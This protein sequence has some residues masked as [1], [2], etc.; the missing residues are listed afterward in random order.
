MPYPTLRD[1]EAGI[2][3]GREDT[4][5]ALAKA[6][7]CTVSDLYIDPKK[8]EIEAS[9]KN[10]LKSLKFEHGSEAVSS[11]VEETVVRT[12][13]K[14]GIT[15]DASYMK[16]FRLFGGLSDEGKNLAIS[17]LESLLKTHSRSSR[18]SDVAT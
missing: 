14:M 17:H 18:S 3:A 1:I 12:L 9:N 2:N 6:L 8:A 16:L 10:G 15:N 11:L 5:E 13:N 7:G 4:K